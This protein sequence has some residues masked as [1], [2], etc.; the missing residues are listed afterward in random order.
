[1]LGPERWHVL[2]RPLAKMTGGYIT[3]AL[4]SNAESPNA[5]SPSLN[6]AAAAVGRPFLSPMLAGSA[7][8][9]ALLALFA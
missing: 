4:R 3:Q 8:M 2:G 9:V 6:K 7:R 1:M 5:D